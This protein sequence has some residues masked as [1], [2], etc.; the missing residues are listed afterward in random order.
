MRITISQ[1]HTECTPS[2]TAICAN[3]ELV[4][5]VK[6][7]ESVTFEVDSDYVEI[8][9]FCGTAHDMVKVVTDTILELTWESNKGRIHLTPKSE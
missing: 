8:D 2:N 6:R 5:A 4:A 7:G 3:R 9:A 1:A